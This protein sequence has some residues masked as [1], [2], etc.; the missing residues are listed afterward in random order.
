MLQSIGR[1]FQK[2]SG[3]GFRLSYAN[4]QISFEIDDSE[5]AL[6]MFLNIEL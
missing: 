1:H 3:V 6:P 2:F 4:D 5:D